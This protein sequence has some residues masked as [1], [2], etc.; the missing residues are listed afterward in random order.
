MAAVWGQYQAQ[1]SLLQVCEEFG[2]QLT[3]FHGPAFNRHQNIGALCQRN[4]T[5]QYI[6]APHP[7]RHA[8]DS[9]NRVIEPPQLLAN[10]SWGLTSAAGVRRFVSES[11]TKKLLR[12]T[13]CR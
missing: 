2:V 10:D 9:I 3:L 1:E 5:G 6:R 12:L 13:S 4:T 7:R 8:D 11:L